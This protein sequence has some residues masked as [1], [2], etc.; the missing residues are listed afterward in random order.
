[1]AKK[2]KYLKLRNQRAEK[3]TIEVMQPGE[4]CQHWGPHKG[5]E[6]VVTHADGSAERFESEAEYA[7]KYE[8]VK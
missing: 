6:V 7:A 5:R 1:M 8:E 3:S 2:Q 4:W